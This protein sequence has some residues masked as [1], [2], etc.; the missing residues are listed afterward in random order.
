VCFIRDVP[1]ARFPGA[2][3]RPPDLSPALQFWGARGF[4]PTY[5]ARPDEPLTHGEA[6]R[7]VWLV[8]TVYDPWRRLA[9]DESL[10]AA[11]DPI[12]ERDFQRALGDALGEP[13]PLRR[14]LGVPAAVPPPNHPDAPITRGDACRLLYQI[15]APHI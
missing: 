10:F 11:S 4:F 14:S 9:F 5:A 12:S 3:E 6:A 8:S 2:D 15:Y 13:S 1:P 7:W